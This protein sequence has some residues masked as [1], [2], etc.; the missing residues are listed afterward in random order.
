MY[1]TVGLEFSLDRV[2]IAGQEFD[3]PIF[4]LT[5]TNCVDLS[6]VPRVKFI[7]CN[8]PTDSDG[9]N[10]RFV[11]YD[12]DKEPISDFG[13]PAK[14][15]TAEQE[16]LNDLL[17]RAVNTPFFINLCGKGVRAQFICEADSSVYDCAHGTL[18]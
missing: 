14:P 15:D 13:F 10:V 3:A 2:S 8:R 12:E 17:L 9:E 7:L 11:F 4:T 6:F 18:H 5:D 16:V 1:N